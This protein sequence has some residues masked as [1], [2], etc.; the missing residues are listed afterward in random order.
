M[1]TNPRWAD[2]LRG[3]R[4]LLT[5]ATGFIGRWVARALSAVG[6]RLWLVAKD[7]KKL[8]AICNS[9]EIK[10]QFLIEDCAKE[11]SFRELHRQA[12]PDIVFNLAGYGVDASEKEESLAWAL[13]V[14]LVE[15][16][17]EAVACSK[18]TGWSGL[19]LVHAGTAAE[20]GS[21]E[22][23][24]KESS[25]A[26][27]I[28]LYG[29][30]KLAGTMALSSVLQRTGLRAITARLFTVYGPGEHD[31]RL[32]PTLL[33]ASRSGDAIKLTGGQQQRDFIYVMDVVEGLL[34]LASINE[35]VPPVVNLATGKLTS[36]RA[37]AAYAAEVLGL[38]DSQLQFGAKPGQQDEVLQGPADTS[39]LRRLLDWVPTCTPRE[40]IARTLEFETCGVVRT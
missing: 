18:A 26:A 29:R 22:G 30:S 24:L 36:V 3:R 12:N 32:L 13:N 11:G 39:Q 37:F 17:A 40:G 9:L 20:Y 27:P 38:E 15:E 21:V 5:G 2:P 28:G 6:A 7:E 31:G 35:M 19:R 33:H 8:G 25:E 16:I 10:G 4:V 1:Q 34:R 14:R 23:V